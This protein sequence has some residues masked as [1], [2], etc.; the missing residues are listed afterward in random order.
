MDIFKIIAL[1]ALAFCFLGLLRHFVRIIKLGNPHDLSKANGSVSKGVIY[2]N[3]TAMMPMHKESAYKHLP[4][5]AAGMI[6]HMGTFLTLLIFV[7]SLFNSVMD[8]FR[9]M[10]ILSLIIGICMAIGTGC[11]IALF[12]KRG[13]SKDLQPLSNVDDFISNAFTT[14][15]QGSA[16]LTFLSIGLGASGLLV[17]KCYAAFLLMATLLF[18]YLPL[19]KLRHVV[20]YFAARYHLGFFYGRR[21]TWPQKKV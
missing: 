6:F 11:G 19:G 17:A 12:V 5:Y 4:T 7:L 8:F 10:T 9:E 20:Y 1:I 3:T 18:L 15:F 2:S 16:M 21:G 14:L 13:I